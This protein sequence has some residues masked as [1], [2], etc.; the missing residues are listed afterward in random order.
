VHVTRAQLLGELK[1][2]VEI[3]KHN[4]MKGA[5]WNIRDLNKASRVNCLANFM[6]QNELD[7]VG[8][9]ETKKIVISSVRLESVNRSMVWNF[10]PA[11]CTA[12][13]ILIGFRTLPLKY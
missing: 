10:I 8:I 4:Q 9:H 1:P 11:K 3:L 6:K 5:F 13:S 7:I 12:C 2:K